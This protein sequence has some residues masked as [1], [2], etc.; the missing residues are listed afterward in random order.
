[1]P[2]TIDANGLYTA[3]KLPTAIRTAHVV[4]TSVANGSTRG[5]ATVSLSISN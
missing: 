3:P 1:M 5:V 2:N 4:A